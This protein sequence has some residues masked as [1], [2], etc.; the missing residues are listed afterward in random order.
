LG[1]CRVVCMRVL[2]L[3]GSS[4]SAYRWALVAARVAAMTDLEAGNAVLAQ[5]PVGV[6]RSGRDRGLGQA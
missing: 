2:C 6:R 3:G 1:A 4:E 5:Q